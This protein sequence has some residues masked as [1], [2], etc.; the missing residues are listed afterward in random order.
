M[1]ALQRLVRISQY[2]PNGHAILGDAVR[3]F[4]RDLRR[5]ASSKPAVRF[6]V[7]DKRL[8]VENADVVDG[9]QFAQQFRDMLVDLGID[10]LEIDREVEAVELAAFFQK[11]ARRQAQAVSSQNFARI[12]FTDLP[13]S[14]RIVHKRFLASSGSST[15]HQETGSRGRGPRLE[16]FLD[17]LR[18]KGVDD[19]QLAHC[20]IILESLS[21]EVSTETTPLAGMAQ[22]GWHDIEQLL[23][24]LVE[25]EGRGDPE[26]VHVATSQESLNS[27]ATILRSLERHAPTKKSEEAINLLVSL[28]NKQP[29]KRD[30]PDK[31][32]DRPTKNRQDEPAMLPVAELQAFV[33][34]HQPPKR[35]LAKLLQPNR[36]EGLAIVFTFLES[37]QAPQVEARIAQLLRD[38]LTTNLQG[39]EWNAVLE[40][41]RQLLRQPDRGRRDEALMLVVSPLRS[42]PHVSSL[43]FFNQVLKR[44]DGGEEK[45]LW[46]FVVNEL[47]R[48]GPLEAPQD[49]FQLCRRM[50]ALPVRDMVEMLPFL[51]EL[52]SCKK[53]TLAPDLCTALAPANYCLFALLLNTSLQPRL[54][55]QIIRVFSEHPQDWVMETVA[56]FLDP[57]QSL[58]VKF[59][60]AY[61]QL[62]KSETAPPEAL[63]SLA[64][65]ILAE[66][67]PTLPR[68]Q[69]AMS[70]VQRAI[71]AMPD[72]RAESS[73]QTLETI[74]GSKYLLFLPQW[75]G[76]C[77]RSAVASLKKLQRSSARGRA[78]P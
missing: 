39:D 25:F 67:L 11:M 58:H 64:G 60:I 30:K 70:F 54:T 59:L 46:P 74:I 76:S 55:M 16:E 78:K 2:Y 45:R 52:D 34:L 22:V 41:T 19:R 37:R 44:C 73:R 10:A 49:F 53:N 8:Y 12:H 27:L 47:M 18:R 7:R 69:R 17:N 75:P 35:R 68:E 3:D 51:Q 5:L 61:L 31:N 66:A 42:S 28:V 48:I 21:S 57:A 56:P 50:A 13:S 20:R 32:E 14:I 15:A 33:T 36:C 65:R 77:R 71:E 38:M 29:I 40:G 26:H 6:E 63:T 4:Q 9:D 24:R 43:F 1:R 62:Y 72:L 23:I